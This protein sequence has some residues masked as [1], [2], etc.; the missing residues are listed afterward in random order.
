MA[1]FHP[2]WSLLDTTPSNLTETPKCQHDLLNDRADQL[3]R[4]CT[5]APSAEMISSPATRILRVVG[6]RDANAGLRDAAARESR[7][8]PY[9]REDIPNCGRRLAQTAKS[10]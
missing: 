4:R 10:A 7:S 9:R 1:T 5:D 3:E 6:G 8:G 2:F